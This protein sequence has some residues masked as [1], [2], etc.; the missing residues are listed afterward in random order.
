MRLSHPHHIVRLTLLAVLGFAVLVSG[1]S[2]SSPSEPEPEPTSISINQSGGQLDAIGATVQLSAEVRDQNGEMMPSA[3]VSWSSSTPDVA[4]VTP[5]GLVTAVSEG[6]TTITAETGS[7]SST[8][9][10]SVQVMPAS[11]HV[12]PQSDT[13]HVGESSAF[14]A[15]VRDANGHVI[16]GAGVSWTT[17][18]PDVAT[19][20]SSDGVVVGAGQGEATIT[21]SSGGASGEATIVVLP[22]PVASVEVNPGSMNLEVGESG[23]LSAI[24]RAEDGSELSGRTVEW[25][26][27]HPS[28]ASVDPN[29]VVTA[30]GPGTASITATSEGVHGSATIQVSE[31]APDVVAV[32]ITPGTASLEIG[33]SRQLSATPRAADGSALTDRSVT[34]S[35]SSNSIA[36]VSSSGVVTAVTSG[37]V[38]ITAES[39]GVEGTARIDVQDDSPEI[40]SVT[41]TGAQR[42]KVGDSYVY[43]ATARYDDGSIANV[44]MSWATPNPSRAQ[45]TS[46]GVLT[47]LASGAITIQVIIEGDTWSGTIEAY[48]WTALTGSGSL[49]L[50]LSADMEI[51]NQNGQSEYPVLVL[52]CNQNSGNF[53]AWVATDNF[54]TAS[55]LV[56][57][58]FDGGSSTQEQWIEFSNYSALGHPG[59]TN[60]QTKSF[61][62]TMAGAR[63]FA[64]AFSE[65]NAGA[66]ATIF[67]VTGLAS[68][69]PPLLNACPS[70]SLVA[71][72]G[73]AEDEA[74]FA[75]MQAKYRTLRDSLDGA[76]ADAIHDS[77]GEIRDLREAR[78]RIGTVSVSFPDLV[79]GEHPEPETLDLERSRN[80]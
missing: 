16:S 51:T 1:C 11:V 40:A 73:I 38:W 59:P 55:G 2:D 61:A 72:D 54:V 33:E 63:T 42:V 53:F 21:A 45:M 50:D 35:S 78:E 31:P 47:P 17:S 66:H 27:L 58:G 56:T 9:T 64:F 39:E 79:I 25:S 71:M 36:T 76:P 7:A 77:F 18:H 48:D 3:A 20:G 23:G 49:F 74:G 24:L 41:L 80:R 34:W 29:G 22:R 44:P 12:A 4:T 13:L 14:A 75:E 28:I 5:S 19:V 62:N 69:L 68:L 57:Y 15:E 46:T 43:S 65:F 67:R 32:D 8:H 30:E 70:N 52:S 37:T 60:L 6:T 26:S 10:L